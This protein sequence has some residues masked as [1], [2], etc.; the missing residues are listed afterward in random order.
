MYNRIN[1]QEKKHVDQLYESLS[2]DARIAQ[3]FNINLYKYK[4]AP[5]EAAELFE[6]H[7]FGAGFFAYSRAED[8][9]A[10][11][12]KVQSASSVPVL[13]SADLVNGAGSRIEG[14][15]LFP[16]QM[17]VGAADSEELAEK[18]GIAT[19]VEGREIGIHW[20]FGPIVD[21]SINKDNS[22]MHTRTFGDHPD[23]VIRVSRGF[24]RGVQADNRMAATVKHFPG[25]GVDDRDSHVCTSINSYDRDKWYETFGRVWQA[26][27]SQAACVMSGH[28]AL[29]WID[30]GINYLGPAPATL[31]APIQIE[32]LRNQLGF[33]GVVVSDAIPMVGFSAFAPYRER[34][35]G[36]IESGSD[37][38]LW[39]DPLKDIDEMK[40][41]MDEGILTES[42]LET[43]VKN[44]LALKVWTGL[45][46][47]EEP[48]EAP[49][50]PYT[51]EDFQAWA[52]EIGEKAVCIVR[53]ENT[54]LPLNLPEGAKV[55]TV[56]LTVGEDTRGYV[57]ELDVVDQELKSR[58]FEVEHFGNPSPDL[59]N[60]RGREFDAVF[61]NVHVMPVYGTTRMV[62]KAV[63]SLWNSF[64]HGHP[65]VV[66]TTFGDPYKL[67]EMPYVPNYVLTFSNTPSSQR[68]VVKAWLG[69]LEAQGRLPVSL[70]GYFDRQ[71]K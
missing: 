12:K 43:A 31:S 67:Y 7:P 19:A 2:L 68:A 49:A 63:M 51:R 34:I 24:I 44:V 13:G 6:K 42:R 5:E 58:G 18:M 28:I 56:T 26:L 70:E 11:M 1:Q 8:V 62:G 32:L 15:T 47:A 29:P 37:M 22:M 4:E 59:L 64:W 54:L 65:A 41:A 30:P 48:A 16:W 17:A 40:R 69:E 45:I 57:K 21:L 66:F 20:T 23:H 35:A 39:T 55:A 10:I 38:I 60:A 52:D 27:L 25:D 71:V 3:V 50:S 46:Q 9:A 53:N 33:G 61:I 14:C 36:N